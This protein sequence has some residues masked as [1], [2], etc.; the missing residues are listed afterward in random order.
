[1]HSQGKVILGL[2]EI[3]STPK[4]RYKKNFPGSTFHSKGLVEKILSRGK[5]SRWD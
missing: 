5:Q 1:M 4:A 3:E 2:N